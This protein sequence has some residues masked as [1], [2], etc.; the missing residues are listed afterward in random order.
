[1]R[2][3]STVQRIFTVIHRLYKNRTKRTNIPTWWYIF[4]IWINFIHNIV[5]NGYFQEWLYFSTQSL[6][7]YVYWFLEFK[8]STTKCDPSVISNDASLNAK[9]EKK[10]FQFT[11]KRSEKNSNKKQIVHI[12]SSHHLVHIVREAVVVAAI[13]VYTILFCKRYTALAVR[14][15]RI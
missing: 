15:I 4:V 9:E 6:H 2:Y 11:S 1:M 3:A 14:S 8:R 12:F 10:Q 7:F 13:I 5:A